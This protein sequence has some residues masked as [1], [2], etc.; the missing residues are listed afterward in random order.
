MDTSTPNSNPERQAFCGACGRALEETDS[1]PFE[2]RTPCPNC[3]GLTRTFQE[4]TKIAISSALRASGTLIHVLDSASKYYSEILKPE[5]D[6]FFAAPATLRSAFNFAR[7]LFHF[8]DWL[9]DGH[10]AQLEAHFGTPLQSPGTFWAKV[11]K[12]DARFGFIRDLANASKHVRLTK[13]PSTSM[14]HVANTSLV[15]GV[16]SSTVFDPSVF[17]TTRV[18]MGDGQTEIQ[19]DDCARA[20]FRYWTDLSQKVGAIA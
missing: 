15:V 12:I 13:K 4:S 16:F 19:F 20:L 18:Q 10:R 3:G 6:E 17:D 7:S 2:D 9:F 8:H 11:E 14:T 1:L 5:H